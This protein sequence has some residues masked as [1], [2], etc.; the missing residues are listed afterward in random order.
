VYKG[1]EIWGV[2]VN[3]D[4]GVFPYLLISAALGVNKADGALGICAIRELEKHIDS[5]SMLS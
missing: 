1:M 5:I 2:P 3:R 4:T